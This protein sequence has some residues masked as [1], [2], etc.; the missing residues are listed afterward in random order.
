MGLFK[1]KYTLMDGVVLI[2][3]GGVFLEFG[4][5]ELLFHTILEMLS[6]VVAFTF[7][8]I[9]LNTMER[10]RDQKIAVL[11]I[12]YLFVGIL[13]IF[14]VLSF[15]GINVFGG[16]ANNITTQIWIAARMLEVFSF[17]LAVQFSMV[18]RRKNTFMISYGLYT[19]AILFLILETNLMPTTFDSIHG[20]STFKVAMELMA[21]TILFYVCVIAHQKKSEFIGDSYVYIF[22]AII[23]TILSEAS[24]VVYTDFSSPFIAFGH[25]FKVLSFYMLYKGVVIAAIKSPYERINK[26]R[27]RLYTMFEKDKDAVLLLDDLDLCNAKI[28][29]ANERACKMFGYSRQEMKACTL[30][31]LVCGSC[32]E[33]NNFFEKK[34][35]VIFEAVL[36]KKN[37]SLIHADVNVHSITIFDQRLKLVDIRDISLRKRYQKESVIFQSVFENT[38]EAIF[39]TNSQN[40]IEWVN[41]SFVK[42]YNYKKEEI[43]G[44]KPD[45]LKSER[46]NDLFFIEMW[47]SILKDDQWVGEIWNRTRS[48]ELIP[49]YQSIVAIRNQDDKVEHY[50]SINVDITEKKRVE[51]KMFQLSYVDPVTKLFNRNYIHDVIPKRKPKELYVIKIDNLSNIQKKHG[52]ET[53]AAVLQKIIDET[54]QSFHFDAVYRISFSRIAFV[55][56]KESNADLLKVAEKIADQFDKPL[57][58]RKDIVNP[59]LYI[60]YTHA[61]DNRED[62]FEKMIENALTAL[63]YIEGKRNHKT[64]E[65]TSELEKS[66][67]EERKLIEALRT[68]VQKDEIQVHFQPIVNIL[69][70]EIVFAEAL[71]RWHHPEKGNISPVRFIPL[72]ER[73]GL[74]VELG[75]SVLRKVSQKLNKWIEQGKEI[76][77]CVNVS[78]VQLGNKRFPDLIMDILLSTSIV[79]NRLILEITESVAIENLEVIKDNISRIT[80]MGVLVALDDFGTGYSSMELLKELPIS[81]IKIDRAFMIGVHYDVHKSMLVAAMTAMAQRLG[82]TVIVEGVED[83]TQLRLVHTNHAKYVQGFLFSKPIDALAFEALL[84]KGT[85]D[86]SQYLEQMSNE[87]IEKSEL[88][89]KRFKEIHDMRPMGYQVLN[90]DGKIMDVNN[91]LALMLGY[92]RMELIGMGFSDLIVDESEEEIQQCFKLA[93]EQDGCWDL[94]KKVKSKSNET[95]HVLLNGS[96]ALDENGKPDKINCLVQ[97]ITHDLEN[98]RHLIRMREV[99]RKVFED[100]PIAYLL[101]DKDYTI[102]EWNTYASAIFGWQKEDVVEE[103]LTKLIWDRDMKVWKDEWDRILSGVHTKTTM[104]NRIKS[105][106]VITTE[107]TNEPIY[108][109]RGDVEFVLSIVRNVTL[110]EEKEREI[111]DLRERMINQ[112]RL[113]EIGQLAAGIAH[114]INN[115]LSYLLSNAEMLHKE[116]KQYV[117]AMLPFKKYALDHGYNPS[118]DLKRLEENMSFI[119]E[120]VEA[121]AESFDEGL[122]KVKDIVS[123]LKT[124]AWKSVEETFAPYDVAENLEKVLIVAYNE[125]KYTCHVEK[126]VDDGMPEIEAIG[127]QINQVLLNFMINAKHAI[128]EKYQDEMGLVKIQATYDETM[129]YIMIE[130]NGQGMNQ[131]T[132]EHVF[133]PFF[134]TK[135]EGVG[136]GLGLS[137]SYEIIVKK[138]KGDISIKSELGQGTQFIIKLP[139]KHPMGD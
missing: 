109:S 62:T 132:Q 91:T 35:S 11:G 40:E 126:E 105:D 5:N 114:E 70:G 120:D 24:F 18:V 129:V 87:Q 6:V 14:H 53:I 54:T 121:I 77:L 36:C 60:S 118:E 71:A 56:F 136:T 63:G 49:V 103:K 138:H 30:N 82:F 102:M 99:Y 12:A 68:A 42:M 80:E 34:S 84:E 52:L 10:M 66:I 50:I 19:S 135:P 124:Y 44:R 75:N 33:E 76:K 72:A 113:S 89:K 46:M 86:M 9:V 137:I 119:E 38:T 97:D 93:I 107:W 131:D 94:E 122:N 47:E 88:E 48:G 58:I 17:L 74:I 8:V 85:M 69:T 45:I 20:L 23:Y 101:W 100:A 61:A 15:P 32:L 51:E 117:D 108:D 1:G 95:K 90:M 112:E 57:E 127:S 111:S 28:M 83:S 16:N 116:F 134:T 13:D 65:Y 128:E 73:N 25:I 67:E 110:L 123:G 37:K 29:M 59:E 104:K 39:I 64:V 41:K 139:V 79:P 106:D 22:W 3:L 92:E 125:L 78:A 98:Q 43:I 130:D 2:I 27:I 55:N 133:E 31:D 115:P 96:I 81:I 4:K 21:I 7:S 26:E